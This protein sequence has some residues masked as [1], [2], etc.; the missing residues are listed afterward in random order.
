MPSNSENK[1][2]HESLC[3]KIQKLAFEQG[4]SLSDYELHEAARNFFGFIELLV[5]CHDE[6][7]SQKN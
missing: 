4:Q 1:T 2:P 6:Q 7:Q 5:Q 3:I